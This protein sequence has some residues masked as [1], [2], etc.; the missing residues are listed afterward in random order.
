MAK[1][2]KYETAVLL[3]TFGSKKRRN[4]ET[5]ICCQIING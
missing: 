5:K 4:N 3:Q 2:K 1:K